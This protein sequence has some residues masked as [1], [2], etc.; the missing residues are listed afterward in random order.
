MRKP[1]YLPP[2]E[3]QE[4]ILRVLSDNLGGKREEIPSEVVKRLGF[5]VV[6]S[7][8]RDVIH[9][10]VDIL[11]SSGKVE[12]SDGIFRIATNNI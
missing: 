10:S 7:Q 4:A 6:S 12:M 8:L 1:E 9:A 11:H 2:T 3:I 5:N